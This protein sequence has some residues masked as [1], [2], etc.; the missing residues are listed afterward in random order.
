MP[1]FS[2]E[3]CFCT[4]VRVELSGGADGSTIE[5]TLRA[6]AVPPILMQNIVGARGPDLF[7]TLFLYYAN[8]DDIRDM[9]AACATKR[10]HP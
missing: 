6:F 10:M 7:R 9:I 8:H 5:L 3:T 1:S 2:P 4:N